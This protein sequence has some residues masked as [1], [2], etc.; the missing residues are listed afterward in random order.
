M[1]SLLLLLFLLFLVIGNGLVVA[2]S[3]VDFGC[4]DLI[5]KEVEV[6]LG[7]GD[8]DLSVL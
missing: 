2:A 3:D 8:A 6:L 4:G 1:L 5:F 7:G